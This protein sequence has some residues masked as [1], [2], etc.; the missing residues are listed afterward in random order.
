M[1][2]SSIDAV[3][4]NFPHPG[5]LDHERGVWQ[6]LADIARHIIE[7]SFLGLNNHRMT[8]GNICQSLAPG[9]VMRTP[10]T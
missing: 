10:V 1:D 4:F 8:W 5:W 9:T 2:F 7:P 6:G 3:V